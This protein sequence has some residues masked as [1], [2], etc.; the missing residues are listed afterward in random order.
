MRSTHSSCLEFHPTKCTLACGRAREKERVRRVPRAEK[1]MRRRKEEGG[2]AGA[3][4]H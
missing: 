3:G 4:P 2:R 1:G